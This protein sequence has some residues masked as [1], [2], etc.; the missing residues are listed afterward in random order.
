VKADLLASGYLRH[1]AARDALA[2]MAF[3]A[4]RAFIDDP[5][6]LKALLCT[7][8]AGKSF[9]VGID[10][11]E[12][13]Q[14]HPGAT[15]LYIGI[16]RETCKR[17]MWK[18]I[19]KRMNT[20][21]T[22]G[23][24]FGDAEMSMRSPNGSLTYFIGADSSEKEMV[25]ALGQKYRKVWIDEAQGFTIDLRKLVYEILK[26]ATADYGGSI[27]LTGTPGDYI[28]PRYA[29]DGQTSGRHLFFAATK[30]DGLY[31]EEP[32]EPGWAVHRWSALDNPHMREAFLAEIAD[33]EE[34]RPLYKAS[35][36]YS[37]MY[38][39]RWA[40]D[41][42]RLVYRYVDERNGCDRAPDG[43]SAWVIGIDLGFNDASTIVVGGWRPHDPTLYIVRALKR[44]GQT[45]SD[46]AEA[47]EQIRKDHPNASLVVDGASRQGVEE[48][49][50]RFRLPLVPAEKA[51]KYDWIRLMN[52][53]FEY[54]MPRIRVVR[55]E[56]LPLLEEW[57][58]LV[59][60]SR[61]MVPKELDSCE[62]HCADAA[63]YL[64]RHAR[65]FIVTKEAPAPPTIVEEMAAY[66]AREARA[67]QAME[68]G[69]EPEE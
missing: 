13:H 14:R 25:K 19:L 50:A 59:W 3:P 2:S 67:G 27:C 4:Q 47:I 61:S 33:I 57:A 16:T 8:R 69:E 35:P 56:C 63:L 62:N 30:E 28:G 64:H 1:V 22:L 23:L 5:S 51:S 66:W 12:E 54:K 26:L 9:A 39:G 11:L 46:V 10:M 41:Q 29:P 31:P 45:F 58:S 42:R 60:D 15:T 18:D 43:I 17:I 68:S 48:M 7:R 38:L 49:K 24:H 36:E 21:L 52:A 65:N 32:R 6:R 20:E 34:S 40:I 53:D 44:A 55:K 37:R